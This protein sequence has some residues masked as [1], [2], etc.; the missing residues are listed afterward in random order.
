MA[1]VTIS[2]L[3]KSYDNGFVAVKQIDLAIRDHEFMVL[4]GPSGCGKSTTLRL[5]AGLEDISSGEIRIGDRVVNDVEPKDR[6]IAMVFQNYALYPHMTV[7]Q[8]LGYALT[9][10]KVPSSDIETKVQQ[11]AQ[12]LSLGDQLDKLP[13]TLSGGQRQRVALGRAIVRQ[14]QVFLFDEPLSNLDAKLRAEM[15]Y[16]LRTLQRRL[17]TTMVY[18]THDQIEALTLGDRI[19][20]MSRGEIQQVATPAVIYEHPCNRFVAGFIGTPAMNFLRGT[21]RNEAGSLAFA[22]AGGGPVI[23]LRMPHQHA[24]SDTIARDTVLGI[25]PEHLAPTDSASSFT[26]TVTLTEQLGDH[27]Y[28]FLQIPGRAQDAPLVMKADGQ[29]RFESGELISLTVDTARCH[30]FAD[31]SEHARTL[32]LPP[33]FSQ[34]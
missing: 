34:M 19:T 15:R 31:A 32:T 12:M 18:V 9:L 11:A 5:I 26:A 22:C 21:I 23:A 2:K 33:R 13:K 27:Q 10:R 3:V 8:N 1:A 17:Q 30:I 20:V 6:D 14:P 4:V 28:V 24:L 29:R 16:E 25:R 7:R